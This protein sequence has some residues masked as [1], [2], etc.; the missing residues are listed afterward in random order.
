MK[1]ENEIRINAQNI[2]R[3]VA[4]M[5]V[6]ESNGYVNT[7]EDDERYEKLSKNLDN[8]MEE[9]FA[10]GCFV[11]LKNI[12]QQ[13]FSASME[14]RKYFEVFSNWFEQ[15]YWLGKMMEAGIEL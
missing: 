2:Y 11:E 14:R 15:P 1:N 9:C 5:E 7:P 3:E 13:M 8:A 10:A 4:T 6:N 12:C